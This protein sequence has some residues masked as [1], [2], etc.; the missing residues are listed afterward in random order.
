MVC[1]AIPLDAKFGGRG[2]LSATCSCQ[3]SLHPRTPCQSY[4]EGNRTDC[5][6]QSP[7]QSLDGPGPGAGSSAIR[8]E[9][10]AF[11]ILALPYSH[12]LMQSAQTWAGPASLGWA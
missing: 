10:C 9:T 5:I 3:A 2:L 4:W 11:L 7:A 8:A 1:V 12:V 6:G